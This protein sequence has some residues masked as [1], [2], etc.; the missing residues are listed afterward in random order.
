FRAKGHSGFAARGK[1]IVCA[2]ASAILHTA[3]LGVVRHLGISARVKADEGYLELALEKDRGQ[4][5]P[6]EADRWQQAQAVLEAAVLGIEE[7]ERQYPKHVRLEVR[8]GAARR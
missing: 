7:I 5:A 4:L 6:A 8:Q 3:A 2:G 1:D